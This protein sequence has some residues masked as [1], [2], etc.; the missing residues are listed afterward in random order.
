MLILQIILSA[1]AWFRGWKWYALIPLTVGIILTL[2]LRYIFINPSNAMTMKLVASISTVVINL[3]L[4]ML[5]IFKKPT[6]SQK[7]YDSSGVTEDI[8]SNDEI[9]QA[10]PEHGTGGTVYKEVNEEP[11]DNNEKESIVYE[12]PVQIIGTKQFYYSRGR[13]KKGPYTEDELV[14]LKLKP[15][16]LIWTEGLNK[17][18]P[19]SDFK[20]IIKTPPPLPIEVLP[21]KTNPRKRIAVSLV[22]LVLL[23]GCSFIST[24]FIMED[25]RDDYMR[26]INDEIDQIFDN[27]TTLCE[28]KKYFIRGE[29]R[30]VSKP[31]KSPDKSEDTYNLELE[32]YKQD[33]QTGA[34]ERFHSEGKGFEYQKLIRRNSG[35][36]VEELWSEDLVYFYEA[37]V[38]YG[39]NPPRRLVTPEEAY[40]SSYRGIINENSECLTDGLSDKLNYLKGLENKYFLISYRESGELSGGWRSTD[41]Y[42]VYYERSFRDYD[43]ADRFSI[44]Q[45]FIKF[46]S[47]FGGISIL[48][49]ILLYILN[50]FKW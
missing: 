8:V 48:L 16:T 41:Y 49:T 27:K 28:G 45:D 32:A 4:L 35:F 12:A 19:L 2:L 40:E 42:R 20:D 13:K 29:L 7:G 14:K 24:Y 6:K 43:I 23:L 33:I 21:Y 5:C 39:S 38:R 36:R 10:E 18:Q 37:T 17:W 25:R 11:T 15:E 30:P 9:K 47:M 1:I 44:R 26:L 46:L 31:I 50:P 34:I 3:V 22:L